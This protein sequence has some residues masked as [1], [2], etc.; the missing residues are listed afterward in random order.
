MLFIIYLPNLS[1]LTLLPVVWLQQQWRG[2]RAP[3]GFD[4]LWRTR[5]QFNIGRGPEGDA[6]SWYEGPLWGVEVKEMPD[7][8]LTSVWLKLSLFEQKV[9]ELP[10][11]SFSKRAWIQV[12]IKLWVD[13]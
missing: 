2:E 13:F 4:Y 11:F 12:D 5:I 6:G 3:V 7:A 1:P 8:D 9:C 10:H